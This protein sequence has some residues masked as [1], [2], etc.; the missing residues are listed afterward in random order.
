MAASAF[1]NFAVAAAAAHSSGST[2]HSVALCSVAIRCAGRIGVKVA[3][4][5]P[6]L[7]PPLSSAAQTNT[8]AAAFAPVAAA[9][10]VAAVASFAS[11]RRAC[12]RTRQEASR[13]GGRK[14]RQTN[15]HSI[16]PRSRRLT[17]ALL[18]V[19]FCSL[20]SITAYDAPPSATP[21]SSKLRS[22]RRIPA[23]GGP[24]RCS[25]STSPSA[26]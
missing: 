25:D 7:L 8:A 26:E 20:C 19:A 16:Q 12:H 14:S 24:T 15:I 17:V 1:G 6:L 23:R 22:W 5:S 3:G 4:R 11:P 18:L 21:R 13:A 2:R 9:A 10:L